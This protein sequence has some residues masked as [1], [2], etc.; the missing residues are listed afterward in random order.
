[1]FNHLESLWYEVKPFVY[2]DIGVAALLSAENLTGGLFGAL[3][4]LTCIIILRRRSCYRKM[5]RS[6]CE[7]SPG[8]S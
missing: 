1:M 4:V 6:R 8:Y 5:L 7:Q 3:L 2:I